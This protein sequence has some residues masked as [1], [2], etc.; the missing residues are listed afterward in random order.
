MNDALNSV[1][2]S[3][4]SDGG[5]TLVELMVVILLL[6]FIALGIGGG[7]HFGSRVWEASEQRIARGTETEH[8]QAILRALFAAALPRKQ[9][10]LVTFDGVRTRIAFDAEA[11]PAMGIAGVA[12]IEIVTATVEGRTQ[13]RLRA[14]PLS[15]LTKVRETI[16]AHDAGQLEFA[17]LDSSEAV[18]AWLASWRDRQRLP[19]AVRLTAS[20]TGT[21]TAWNNFVARLPIAQTP[22]CV[23]D[24]ETHDCK[25][26]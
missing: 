15:D 24:P 12:R 6:G 23:F 25:S 8:A 5:F 10:D 20:G 4:R 11:M 13:L 18:P 17:F 21:R 2:R 26:G 14:A 7:I 22:G 16:L 19:D 3:A 1:I 9:G